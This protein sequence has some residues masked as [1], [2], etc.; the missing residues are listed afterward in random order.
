MQHSPFS[1][2]A[3]YPHHRAR[4]LRRAA[5]LAV[6][7]VVLQLGPAA[8]PARAFDKPVLQCLLAAGKSGGKCVRSAM[9]LLDEVVS[10]PTGAL[11][12]LLDETEPAVIAKCTSA[13]AEV[14]GFVTLDDV[15]YRVNEACES[16]ALELNSIV[17]DPAQGALTNEQTKCR[18]KISK[19]AQK[20]LWKVDVAQA[21]KCIV[22]GYKD[23]PCDGGKR[24]ALIDAVRIKTEASLA[25]ACGDDFDAVVTIDGATLDE[26]IAA[27]VDLLV[28]RGLHYAE[29]VYPPNFLWPYSEFGPY[30][31]G[32]Q[33]LEL[34][35]ASR[36]NV[37][38]D[39]PRPVTVEVY[40][41]STDAAVDGVPRD[42]VTI[43]GLP[44]LETPAY[45]DVPRDPG[46]YPLVVFSHGNNG[47]RIQSFF[48]AAHLASH[49]YVVATPDHH[50]NT[51][52]DTLA[53]TVD[54]NVLVNRPADMS[55]VIDEMLSMNSTADDFFE[56]AID[57]ARIG[58]SGHSFGGLTDFLLAG[59]GVPQ[60]PRIVAMMPQ[61]PAAPFGS[62][63]LETITIPTLIVGG[64]IDATTPFQTQQQAPFDLMLPGPSVVGLGRIANAGHFSFS[65]FC[66]VPPGVLAF[67]GGASEACEPRHLPWRYAQDIV[68]YLAVSFFDGTLKDDAAA[69]A[70]LEASDVLDDFDYQFK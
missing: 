17:F 21:K 54:P 22:P 47:I 49:G 7:A 62:A 46:T 25:A 41:P 20:V 28:V 16:F 5:S 68:K 35:D 2:L 15:T 18:K 10:P 40:Y 12:E 65:D 63:F 14:L 37:A 64:S 36:L 56:D 70:R 69:L 9:K 34:F 58:A 1:A 23:K 42:L 38:G 57:P 67:L 27:F 24:D 6:A 39:G 59:A 11:T 45:R 55:F 51:F 61:A 8:S 44:I 48:F 3:S 30:P 31:V 29:R 13:E 4:T 52:L 53:G 60:D 19:S 33:T 43:L 50:G 32:V 26:R 66:E